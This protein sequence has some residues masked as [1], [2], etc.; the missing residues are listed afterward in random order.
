MNRVSLSIRSLRVA[1][2][3]VLLACAA[4]QASYAQLIAY[5]GFD[6]PL[7]DLETVGAGALGG[8]TGWTPGQGW[9]PDHDATGIVPGASTVVSNPSSWGYTDSQGNQLATSGQAFFKTEWNSLNRGLDLSGVDP[10][11]LRVGDF[12]PFISGIGA[13]G[14]E[15]WIS[16]LGRGDT[17]GTGSERSATLQLADGF[18]G[19]VDNVKRFG[20]GRPWKL[21]TDGSNGTPGDATKN[22]AW[23]IIDFAPALDTLAAT[24]EVAVDTVFMVARIQYF[25]PFEAI[26]GNPANV[27]GNEIVTVW[28]D[29]ILGST[30]P[31]DANAAVQ[32]FELSNNAITSIRL[33]GNADSWFDEIRIGLDYASVAPIAVGTDGDFDG[34]SDVDGADFLEWQRNLG[35]ATNLALWESNFGAPSPAVGA[36]TAVP[37]PSSLL[38]ASAL[39][40]VVTLSRR[41]LLQRAE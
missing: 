9:V 14:A 11:L 13:S 32:N 12:N 24:G 39:A 36:A 23:G 7:G 31:S 10:A 29:P 34:D 15:L 19:T 5:E 4:S 38:L 25:D 21:Q 1:A 28:T 35:D 2:C 17:A 22:D 33:G 27:L 18:V 37:E 3:A 20:L 26:P 6:Y 41:T 8:G 30:Q 40:M 16:F